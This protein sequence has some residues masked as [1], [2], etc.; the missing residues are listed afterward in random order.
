MQN[1]ISNLYDSLSHKYN[2]EVSNIDKKTTI[3]NYMSD[4]TTDECNNIYK[5]ILYNYLTNNS[6]PIMYPFGIKSVNKQDIRVDL[7]KLPDE[8]LDVIY[9]FVNVTHGSK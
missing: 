1:S 4:L 7:T 9:K 2:D 6:R 3:M 8:L 5:L